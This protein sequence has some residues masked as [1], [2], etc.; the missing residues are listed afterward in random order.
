MEKVADYIAEGIAGLGVR[1]VFLVTGGGAMH[2]DD[3]LG[4]R[5]DLALVFDHHEQACAIAAEGNARTTGGIG[6]VCVTTGPG[7]TNTITGVLGQWHDSIPALYVSGQVRRDTT[8]ASTALPLRQLGDQEADIVRLVAPITKYAVSIVEPSSVRYHFEKATWLATHGRPGPVWLDIPLNVQAAAVEPAGLVGFDP[9]ELESGAA[10]GCGA[11]GPPGA[12]EPPQAAAERVGHPGLRPWPP[13]EAA[14]QAPGA[15]SGCFDREAARAAARDALRRLRAAERPVILAGGA[16]RTAGAYELFLRAIDLLGVPVCTAWNAADLLWDDHPLFAG[17][18][19]SVGERAGN[20]ALQ[21]ADVVLVL[22][23]RLNVRQVG[24]EFA[25]FAHHAYRI[26]VDIDEAELA[27]PTISPD[28]AVHADVGFF[29][30]ELA[31]LAAAEPSVSHA[32]WM[33]WCTERRRRYPVV[34]PEYRRREA[35]VNPYVFVEKLAERLE[36]G[37]MVVC[38]NGS[39]CV[40]GIQAFAFKRGQR[41][42]VNSGTAGMGY[43]LPAAVGAAFARRT[44]RSGARAGSGKRVV[45]LA[46]DGSIQM[47]IQELQTIVQHQLPIKIFVFDNAGYASIRQTQDNLFAGRRVGEGPGSGVT[48]PDLVR[49]AEAYGIEAMRVFRHDELD[50]AIEAALVNPS[51]T[52][53]DVVMDP[54]QTF[55]PKVIAERLP[56]GRLVSKPLEDMFPF[57]SREEF[58]ENLIVPPYKPPER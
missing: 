25:A 38:A 17:R 34:L 19:G 14:A 7:G 56:D 33:A 20:F 13:V 22:G 29:L 54:D 36:P 12:L 3:A 57:L 58:A 23:C 35:P 49:V 18:P 10:G 52:L 47:N 40:V 30:E 11:A 53:V 16:L 2:L 31:G 4:R 21:N 45:C 1:H 26:V 55:M 51:P 8:V 39:A 37:D 28:L 32:D 44:G 6:V 5:R 46:G 41:L 27:K 15:F 24:Y 42:L 43:D 9:G 48:F 50:D